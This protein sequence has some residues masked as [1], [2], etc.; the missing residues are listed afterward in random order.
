MPRFFSLF[1]LLC[2]CL[3]MRAQQPVTFDDRSGLS[4]WRV[5][6]IVQDR[7]GFI[8]FAT[9]NGLN[10]FDGYEF[11][12]VKPM[13][14]DGSNIQS[15]VIRRIKVDDAG[16][17]V[18]GTD[19]GSFLLD[20]RDY[21]L[22]DCPKGADSSS[23]EKATRLKDR[24]GNVWQVERYGV[25]K[26]TDAHH[27]ARLV[28][29]TGQV[30][31]RAFMSERSGRWWLATKEDAT[32]R[33]FDRD[34]RLVGYLGP[35]GT[36]RTAPTAFGYRAY[37]M[38]E[39][40]GGDIWIGCKP[41]ALLRL[42]PVDATRYEVRRIQPE[43][44]TCDVIYHIVEDGWGRLWLATFADGIQC[45]ANPRAAD[46]EVVN[47]V[48]KTF[49]KGRSK[50][51]RLLLMDN[52]YLVCTSSNG[53]V[54][55]VIGQDVRQTSFR[56]LVRDGRDYHSLAGN[57]TM[58]VASDAQGNVY[59]ST[60]NNGI[61]ETTR[62]SLFSDSPRFTHHSKSNSTLTSDACMALTVV[63][64]NGRLL[65]VCPDRV[66]EWDPQH[67]ETVTYSKNFWNAASHFS[68]ERPM[69]LPGGAWLFGQEQ[70]AY[71]ASDHSLKSRGYKPPVVFTELNV[72]G[73]PAS[74]AVTVK[75]TI[76]IDTD[77][78]DFTVSYAA[79]DY[80]D[81]SDICYRNRVNGGRWNYSGS[82]HSLTFYDVQPGSYLLEVQSTDHYG[83]W[84]DNGRQL[85]IVVTPHWYETL[86][87]RIA[88][89][90]LAVVLITAVVYTLL[91]IRQLSRQRRE[92]LRKYMRLMEQSGENDAAPAGEEDHGMGQL[93]LESNDRRFMERVRMY[94]E[95]NIANED[96]NL[97]D[98][99]AY[100]AVSRST[101]NRKLKTLVGITATQLLIEARM[102]KACYLLQHA[103]DEKPNIAAIAYQCGYT[104]PKYFSRCFKQKYG[105]APSAS[106]VKE[107]PAQ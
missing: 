49:P 20:I 83:R 80:T 76:V 22:K 51:R 39:T 38:V 37:C 99:A 43:G 71:I 6:G 18:C 66:M 101:L 88:A 56:R 59:V 70:G 57:A 69:R 96:A 50:M 2:C 107:Q 60:E 24:E 13:P 17:I 94:I 32:I 7:Q 5:S 12:Q 75:D 52:R 81:N 63:R 87:A 93:E 41:G 46:P 16:N 53:L 84:A 85:V 3:C 78:R 68:E 34:N 4:H 97:E 19:A 86:W 92:L 47:F 91:Y 25:T 104:D 9:W 102:Q 45:V 89:G 65:M 1:L 73:K 72:N 33:I 23:T 35:D 103:G 67:D 74:L 62:E 105:V 30:Q 8:W 58:D 42:R 44:L 64:D 11:R 54:T 95:E 90:L 31:A 98:M 10:R 14:G 79:L 48:G 29:G 61:E 15:E 40:A 100:A 77:E 36:I 55:G 82:R 106:A 21:R 26:T 27:P 28:D